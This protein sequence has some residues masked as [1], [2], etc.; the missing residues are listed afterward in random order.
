MTIRLVET[1][2]GLTLYDGSRQVASAW[3]PHPE[4][5]DV[6]WSIWPPDSGPCRVDG[7]RDVA[8]GLMRE[9]R[10]GYVGGVA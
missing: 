3:A 10:A 8:E 4:D 9:C 1:D 6:R 2:V 5:D 7:G